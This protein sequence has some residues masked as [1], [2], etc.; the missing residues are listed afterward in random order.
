MANGTGTAVAVAKRLGVQDK[1]TE[2]EGVY[3]SRVKVNADGPQ[4]LLGQVPS[5]DWSTVVS[6][7]LL[8]PNG[9]RRVGHKLNEGI[10]DSGFLLALKQKGEVGGSDLPISGKI[11]LKN[12]SPIDEF[13]AESE[14]AALMGCNL[15][16][17]WRSLPSDSCHL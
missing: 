2:N 10:K 17:C 11:K 6:C 5:L 14:S 9:L 3:Y 12:D 4:T 13:A 16:T 7:L 8:Y 1:S 15:R